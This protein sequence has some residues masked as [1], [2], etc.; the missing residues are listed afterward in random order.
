MSYKQFL[1][2]TWGLA[3]KLSPDY[4]EGFT[5][6]CENSKLILKVLYNH[7]DECEAWYWAHVELM[8]LKYMQHFYKNRIWKTLRIN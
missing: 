2:E 6:R 5:Q 7:A 4:Y 8:R 3:D 1:K